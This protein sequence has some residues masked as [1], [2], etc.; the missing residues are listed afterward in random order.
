MVLFIVMKINRDHKIALMW[1]MSSYT[2]VICKCISQHSL[3]NYV[4]TNDLKL[5]VAYDNKG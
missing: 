2:E 1:V 5:S 4:I 3:S